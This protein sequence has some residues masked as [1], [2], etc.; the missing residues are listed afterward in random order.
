MTFTINPLG[1]GA[2]EI[3]GL[4]CSQPFAGGVHDEVKRAFRTYP[5]LV[6]RDQELSAPQLAAFGRQ[7]GALES[8]HGSASGGSGTASLRQTGARGTPDQMLYQSPEDPGVLIMTNERREGLPVIGIV[9]NA[10]MWHSDASHKMEPCKAIIVHVVRNPASGGDTEFCDLRAVYDAL[11]PEIK[12]ALDGRIAWHHWSKS[13]NP[14][15]AGELD[16][17]AQEEGARIVEMIPEM[18]QPVVRTHP[19]SGRPS[20]YLSPRFTLRIGDIAPGLSAKML[21]ELFAFAEDPA[22]CY[23]HS[24]REKDL[25]IWDN[26]CLNHRVRS[27]PSQDIRCRLRVTVAGDRPFF[28]RGP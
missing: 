1:P 21:D 7:F 25:V 22:F 19:E 12:R 3:I 23:R 15:F 9:D 17:A 10:E 5:V 4:D 8:Y 26:R 11:T 6:F 24:W 18:H 27:Y 28:A 2:A 20:L 13:L 16:H 14:R